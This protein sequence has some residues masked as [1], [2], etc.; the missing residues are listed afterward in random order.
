VR[1]GIRHNVMRQLWSS[2]SCD[3]CDN[4]VMSYM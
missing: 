2:R 3:C 1:P 4:T